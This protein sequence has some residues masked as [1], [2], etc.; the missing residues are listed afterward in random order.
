[1]RWG[2]TRMR[3]AMTRKNWEDSTRPEGR[4]AN[5]F[6]VGH[7]AIEFLLDFGLFYPENGDA[8]LHTRIITSPVYAKALLHTIRKS[9]ERYEQTFG[10]LGEE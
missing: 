8:Q 5:Y 3:W 1:M 9:I 10:T 4:Y 7:N 2:M 6:E